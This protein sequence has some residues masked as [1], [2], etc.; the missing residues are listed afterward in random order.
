MSG[1]LTCPKGNKLNL[2][3]FSSRFDPF[4]IPTFT[5][6][7][8]F[9]FLRSVP[10]LPAT[11]QTSNRTAG[12]TGFGYNL[13]TASSPTSG[14]RSI[15]V[16]D[17]SVDPEDTWWVAAA[18]GAGVG[19]GIVLLAALLFTKFGKKSRSDSGARHPPVEPIPTGSPN[20]G[21]GFADETK[22]EPY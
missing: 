5:F 14:D 20:R 11:T 8:P 21:D 15:D 22:A 1:W 10:A 19:L 9:P 12:A 16:S 4:L 17:N 7:F 6:T 2:L 13:D 3:P 18:G